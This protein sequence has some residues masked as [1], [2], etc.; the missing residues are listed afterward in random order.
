MKGFIHSIETFGTLDGPG[1]RYVL[2]MQ[3]C[4]LRC[5]Y[6]HNPDTWFLNKD[7]EVSAKEIIED[8]KNY[9][10]FLKNGGLTVSGGEPLLQ[11][12]FLLDLF[13]RAKGENIHTAL[14]TS[15]ITFK[16]EEKYIFKLRSLLQNAD[17]VLLDLK[18]IDSIEHKKL[19][20][21]GNEEILNFAKFLS[22]ENIP[23][24]IRH[25]IVPGI[26]YKEEYLLKLGN[27]IGTLKNVK[28]V[29]VLPY[30]NLG[31]NKYREL[32][33]PYTLENVK[34]L[35]AKEAEAAYNIILYGMRE[36][37]NKR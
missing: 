32:Q 6:C 25:V 23:T 14:D 28:A 3:G 19:T 1:I 27:F 22:K 9:K 4:P 21:K 12:D 18:H 36:T 24:W 11:L 16:E 29:E 26:T 31:I 15:G 34:S 17:L 37:L 5:L 35:S 30:H 2:F 7:K 33:L 20:G 8:Y 13:Q 10:S